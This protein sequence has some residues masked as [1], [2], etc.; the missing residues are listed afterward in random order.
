MKYGI[1]TETSSP[2][3][4]LYLWLMEGEGPSPSQAYLCWCRYWPWRALCGDLPVRGWGGPDCEE[5]DKV[6]T[7]GWPCLVSRSRY[8][9]SLSH[10]DLH[11]QQHVAHSPWRTTLPVSSV[12]T[13]KSQDDL[14]WWQQQPALE[15][16]WRLFQGQWF[17]RPAR[18]TLQTSLQQHFTQLLHVLSLFN[19]PGSNSRMTHPINPL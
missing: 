1:K 15:V 10:A 2:C 4:L 18:T 9:T 5:Q 3:E 6:M 19:Y 11:L 12:M 7:L 13:A 14:A 8:L 16:T 17:P